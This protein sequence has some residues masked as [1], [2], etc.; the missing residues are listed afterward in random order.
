MFIRLLGKAHIESGWHHSS[1]GDCT[2][3]TILSA[4]ECGYNVTNSLK[5]PLLGFS[6]C[7][8]LSPV[9]GNQNEPFLL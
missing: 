4:L 9:I 3:V 1:A 8:E 2:N 7:D 5:L 6:S